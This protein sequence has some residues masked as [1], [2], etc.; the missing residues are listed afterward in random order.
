MFGRC[1]NKILCLGDVKKILCLRDVKKNE[2]KEKYFLKTF[3]KKVY[4]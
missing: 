3:L 2:K 4:L 1:T